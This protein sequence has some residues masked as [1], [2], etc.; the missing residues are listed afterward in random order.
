M[1]LLFSTF[2]TKKK[3]FTLIELLVVIAIIGILSAIVLASLGSARSRARDA[4][5]KSDLRQIANALELYYLEK[6]NYHVTNTN[7][8][9]CGAGTSNTSTAVG[10]FAH[11]GDATV[12]GLAQYARAISKCLVQ[13]N[14]LPQ[15]IIDPSREKT[16]PTPIS[17]SQRQGYMI[18]TK[19]GRYLLWA[20]LENPSAADIA[21]GTECQN[22]ASPI[23]PGL[24]NYNQFTS[25]Y[26]GGAR[27][28][29]CI[30]N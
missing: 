18:S 24:Q 3:G 30:H 6:G 10:Y 2:H 14:L 8:D 26:A 22:I 12:T 11:G 25:T 4:Q 27:I 29:Y 9:I 20:N 23:T 28:N 15:E 7:N 17:G 13:R 19:D 21:S 1:K 5:R 16:G